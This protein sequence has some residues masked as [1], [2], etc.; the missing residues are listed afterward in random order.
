MSLIFFLTALGVFLYWLVWGRFH[1]YTNDAYVAGNLVY[2]TPQV[3]SIVTSIYVDDTQLVEEGDL[4]VELDRT[5]LQIAFDSSKAA[6][7]DTIRTVVKL[8]L[9][10][11]ESAALIEVA[12][13]NFVQC[14]LDFERR[15]ALIDSGSVSEEDLEHSKRDLYSSYFSLISQEQHF[16]SLFAETQNTSVAKHPKV[17]QSVEA[18]KNAWVQLGR[19]RIAAPVGGLVARRSVQVGE[20]V[21]PADPLLAIVP[22]DQLW[23]DANFKEVQI[24]KMQIGQ[25]A[26]LRSDVY[27][28][29]IDYQGKVIGIGGGTGSVFSLL[30]PQNATGNWIKIVQRLPVRIEL[31]PK[32]VI[33]HPL[34]LGL[35]MEVTVDIHDIQT[36][37]IPPPVDLNQALYQTEVFAEEELGV[38]KV[39]ADIFTEN[40]PPIDLDLHFDTLNCL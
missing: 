21:N 38:E 17:I 16:L 27:G 40:I 18:V 9:D 35:S 28:R 15:K 23:V 25:P 36:S 32:E 20:R 39:I 4:V 34:R 30:P 14:A 12:K 3:S 37:S 22:L 2:V 24:G 1:E 31:D 13:A 7:A 8:F 19:C 29:S 10:T 5:D 11:K 6:L 33:R 26:H